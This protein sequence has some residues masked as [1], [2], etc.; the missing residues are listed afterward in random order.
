MDTFLY[1]IYG[2]VYVYIYICVYTYSYTY[3]YT[4]KYIYEY[5]FVTS[6][7]FDR[8]I[9]GHRFNKDFMMIIDTID[10]KEKIFYRWI[11]TIGGLNDR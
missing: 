8:W 7:D 6:S 3:A 4:Y 5:V 10:Q 1:I 2:N 9:D 11:D